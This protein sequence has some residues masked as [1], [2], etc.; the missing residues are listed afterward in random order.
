MR[1]SYCVFAVLPML[2]ACARTGRV[3]GTQSD[4]PVPLARVAVA[5]GFSGPESARYDPHRDR[6]YVSN[7]NG[8]GYR[9]DN[10]GFISRLRGDG[11]IEQLEFIAGG[12][13][14]TLLHGPTGLEITGD[15]LWVVDID[16]VRAFDI[17]RGEPLFSVDVRPLGALR[18]NDIAVGPDG[19]LYVT[20]T[21]VRFD[22]AGRRQHTGPDRIFR[23]ARDRSVS[24]ALEGP[25]LAEPNGILFDAARR[26]FLLAPVAGTELQ[27]WQPGADVPVPL[28]TG[29]GGFDGIALLGDDRIFVSSWADS[30]V[31]EVR[32]RTVVPVIRGVPSVADIGFDASRRHLALP[33]S[34][35]GR[36]EFWRIPADESAPVQPAAARDELFAADR[37][38]AARAARDGL[39]AGYRAHLSDDAIYLPEL[40]DYIAGAPAIL[41]YLATQQV[42]PTVLTWAPLVGDVSADGRVGYTVGYRTLTG[43]GGE[44]SFSKYIAFWRKATDGAWRVEAII[45]TSQRLAPEPPPAGYARQPRFPRGNVRTADPVAVRAELLAIDAAFAEL[46]LAKG[47]GP[48]FYE[49]TAPG[50]LLL[51]SSRTQIVFGREAVVEMISAGTAGDTLAWTPVLAGSGPAGDLGWTVGTSLYTSHAADGSPVR[52]HGKYLSIWERLPSGRWHFVAD[53]GNPSPAPAPRS[54]RPASADTLLGTPTGPFIAVS[55]ADLDRML[56]WYRDTL[57][58]S[59]HRS[60]IS[61]NGQ[62]RFALLRSGAALVELLQIPGAVPRAEAAPRTTGSHQIHG[63]FKSGLV[64]ADIDRAYRRLQGMGVRFDYDLGRPAENPMRSFGVRDPEGNL[65]QFFGP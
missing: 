29:A 54:A 9:R 48:A 28:A 33:L 50:G 40:A 7:I 23:I 57:G 22:S 62:I 63:F 43:A 6:W 24:V 61:P 42:T 1:M 41:S 46:S 65:V 4:A 27:A 14:A 15:T 16:A 44:T 19:A 34:R 21:G 55:V 18:L 3:G 32:G 37:A 35:D 10:N 12:R 47:T 31:G 36:V 8:P 52:Y 38:F 11:T 17:E 25:A 45:V 5:T 39:V 30:S 58:F 26:R 49:Y 20:D 64:V 51:G 59:V 60:G 13:D 53:G 2:A 56:A